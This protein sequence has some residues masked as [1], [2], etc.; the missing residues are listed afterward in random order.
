VAASDAGV[1]IE[2]AGQ[3]RRT[4]KQGGDDLSDLKS[5][6]KEVATIA[7]G[8]ARPLAPV[9]LTGKLSKTIRASGTKTAGIIRAGT[10]R[11]PYANPIHWGWYRRH[12][13]STPFLTDGAQRSETRWI[14]VYQDYVES[15]LDQVEGT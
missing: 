8:A 10:A 11:V 7:A 14:G 5:T 2:G 3:F 13:K 15:A 6:H 4:L 9:G 1:R 12:I